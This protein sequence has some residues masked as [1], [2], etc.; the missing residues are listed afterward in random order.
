MRI[1]TRGLEPDQLATVLGERIRV[2][3]AMDAVFRLSR[4][5]SILERSAF[6]MAQLLNSELLWRNPKPVA[7]PG[8]QATTEFVEQWILDVASMSDDTVAALR[9][10]LG[11]D[12]L[13]D[14]IH[15]LLVI[16]QRIRLD[17]AWQCLKLLPT[18]E[19]G[20]T[21]VAHH[22]SHWGVDQPP[23][24][25]SERRP[26]EAASCSG[27]IARGRHGDP[28]LTEALREWQAAVVCLDEVDPV[29]TELV[30][31]RCANYHDCHT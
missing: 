15:S 11:D 5:T 28:R 9:D 20:D 25:D 31:L 12:A 22:Q 7:G 6:R 8:D 2:N 29:T 10:M 26:T 14:F 18:P 3:E 24:N 16:E 21:V 17:L 4:R 1:S 19:F 13:M 27:R 30:R 23:S